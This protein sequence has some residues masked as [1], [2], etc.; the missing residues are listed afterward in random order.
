M[1]QSQLFLLVFLILVYDN[2]L[3]HIS[4]YV[5]VLCILCDAASMGA[6]NCRVFFWMSVVFSLFPQKSPYS[7]LISI[8]QQCVVYCS[9]DRNCVQVTKSIFI[10]NCI[11]IYN[12]IF[13]LPFLWESKKIHNWGFPSYH[14]HHF[15]RQVG[16]RDG[17]WVCTWAFLVQFP[18]I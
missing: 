1:S 13:I 5:L 18:T 2:Y 10:Y 3:L 12:Y 4:N 9:V 17:E 8:N 14:C 6:G 16:L 7:S 15:M 11:F